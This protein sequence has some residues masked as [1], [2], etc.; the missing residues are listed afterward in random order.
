[1]GRQDIP[2]ELTCSGCGHQ[3]VVSHE[4]MIERLRN[5]GMLRRELRPGADEVEA[6]SSSAASR[7]ACSECGTSG[8]TAEAVRADWESGVTCAACGRLIPAE[9]V[10]AIPDTRFC[11][12]CQDEG[13]R[14]VQS[15]GEM[16]Y[17][18][19]C[20]GLLEMRSSRGAGVTRWVMV[21]PYGCRQ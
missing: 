8:V 18:A 14:G 20:G 12:N 17:C 15:E 6:L 21:C 1:M 9:R 3:E 4:G 11:V 16:E 7:I 13:E 5:V 2:W 10:A 19:K